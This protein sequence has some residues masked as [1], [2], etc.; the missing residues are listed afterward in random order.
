MGAG[1]RCGCVGWL[2]DVLVFGFVVMVLVFC[3]SMVGVH[4]VWCGLWVSK[5]EWMKMANGVV[6]LVV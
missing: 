2:E 6:I 3:D 5:G 1:S 4:G